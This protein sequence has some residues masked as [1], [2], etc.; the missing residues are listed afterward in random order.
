MYD[1]CEFMV[2]KDRRLVCYFLVFLRTFKIKSFG[3]F[4]KCY[5][6]QVKMFRV[7]LGKVEWLK[8]VI[9]FF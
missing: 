2:E 5:M 8:I 1:L 3:N 4:N 6:Y 9:C 7:S